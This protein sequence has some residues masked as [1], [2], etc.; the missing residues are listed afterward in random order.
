MIHIN[1]NGI[2]AGQSILQCLKHT[3]CNWKTLIC[4]YFLY[5]FGLLLLLQSLLLCCHCWLPQVLIVFRNISLRQNWFPDAIAVVFRC[6]WYRGRMWIAL[7][8]RIWITD[9]IRPNWRR[10]NRFQSFTFRSWRR[11]F[12]FD[13][14]FCICEIRRMKTIETIPESSMIP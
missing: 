6:S 7:L 3:M 13:N 8:A 4:H 11:G 10:F 12:R 2:H 5:L 14:W 1:S 9:R